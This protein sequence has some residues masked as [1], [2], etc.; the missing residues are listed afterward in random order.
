M[1]VLDR[2]MTGP[3]EMLDENTLTGLVVPWGQDAEIVDEVDGRVEHYIEA[4]D[5]GAFDAQARSG[6]RGTIAKI[7]MVETHTSGLGKVGYALELEDRDA[8]QFGVFRILPR[9]REDVGQMVADGVD[10]LSI[11]FIPKVGGTRT[12]WLGRMERRVRTAA[13]MVHVALVPEPAYTSARVHGLRDAAEDQALE[14]AAAA[15]HRRE[16]EQLLAAMD[17]SRQRWEHLL[18]SDA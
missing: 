14:E 7:E 15:E 9:F 3:V 2:A 5:R 1:R 6:N 11:R 10:G 18:R 12:A 13:H 16:A 8:G 4:F 17:E